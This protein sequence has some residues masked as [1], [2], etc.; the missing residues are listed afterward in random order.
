MDD[1]G[2]ARGN[3]S[4]LY[5]SIIRNALNVNTAMLRR[6]V[7]DQYQGKT[8]RIETEK[9]L[10]YKDHKVAEIEIAPTLYAGSPEKGNSSQGQSAIQETAPSLY[11]GQSVN[12]GVTQ[13]E[14]AICRISLSVFKG[15]VKPSRIGTGCC[16][17]RQCQKAL[18]R[19]YATL[20]LLFRRART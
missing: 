6:W 15:E 4:D 14:S 7:K 3:P 13:A 17:R 18:P 10:H 20:W 8:V 5:R 16:T 19:T 2:K 1:S 9:I 12:G 11:R